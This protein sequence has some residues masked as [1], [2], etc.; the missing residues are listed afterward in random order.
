V[1]RLGKEQWRKSSCSN[2][3]CLTLSSFMHFIPRSKPAVRLPNSRK[4]KPLDLEILENC[5]SLR[6]EAP[7][8]HGRLKL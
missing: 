8:L 2:P 3:F 5:Y 4:K 1:K 7:R 6:W